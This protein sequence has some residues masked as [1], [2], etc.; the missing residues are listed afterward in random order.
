[1]FININSFL[2][3]GYLIIYIISLFFILSSG[4]LIEQW[5]S[6]ELNIFCFIP[7][8]S[9][10]IEK[11]SNISERICIYFLRQRIFSL[12]FLIG[13]LTEY[14]LIDQGFFFIWCIKVLG[15][16]G[17]LGIFP[18]YFWVPKTIIGIGFF[19]VF[20]ILTFQ[21]IGPIFLIES[22]CLFNIKNLFFLILISLGGFIICFI[23]GPQQNFFLGFLCYSSIA[24]GSWF[25]I[26]ILCSI[27]LILIY[28]LIYSL[29]LFFFF[30]YIKKEGLYIWNRNVD[31]HFFNIQYSLGILF[32]G[33]SIGGLP[34]TPGF[35]VKLIIIFKLRIIFNF[36]FFFFFFFF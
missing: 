16:L 36:F 13:F 3:L 28:F 11:L 9:I 17:K 14:F 32:F 1:M 23:S 15:L 30:Y 20:F 18:F 25:L 31:T 29:N 34:P 6:L 35:F 19:G 8:C 27:R 21:K 24:H 33:V 22:I 5:I 2:R 4:T 7:I 10:F 26:S 12:L